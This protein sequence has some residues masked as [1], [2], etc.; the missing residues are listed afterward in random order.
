VTVAAPGELLRYFK[1]GADAPPQVW[2]CVRGTHPSLRHWAGS[3]GFPYIL[4]RSRA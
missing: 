4:S 2:K 3:Q 1:P